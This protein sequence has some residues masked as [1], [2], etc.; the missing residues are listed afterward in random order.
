[1][2]QLTPIADQAVNPG[3]IV[4]LDTRKQEQVVS[5]KQ[6]LKILQLSD[7]LSRHLDVADILRLFSNEISA[8]VRH[9]SYRFVSNDLLEPVRHG[10]LASHS[11]NYHLTIQSMD[12]GELS[13]Y[14]DQPFSANEVCQI[15]DLLCSLI[16][17]LRN[18][19]MYQSAL[20]SAYR[21]P[22]TGINNRAALDRLMPRE[23]SLAKRHDYRM[24]MM[25]M[26]LDGFKAINDQ[27]GHDTGDQVLRLASSA[28]Q[29]SLRESDMLFRYGGDEFVAALPHTD[30]QGAID[31][32]NRIL[33]AINSLE[34]DSCADDTG[35]GISIGLSMLT[36]GDDFEGL[37]KRVDK[38][39]YR[40]KHNGKNQVVV[41]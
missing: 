28:V 35:F 38:A 31:V 2:P 3:Q 33:T 4:A 32:A 30:I 8:L 15:E 23:I 5:D 25:V 41:T 40:A 36:S 34:L 17:P 6:Y 20:L 21:D 26:D 14:R 12:L 11:L 37:F 10:A 7:L 24:A 29:T 16:Y 1:M 19:L 22:L 27:C 13:I 18:A 9:T 39:L